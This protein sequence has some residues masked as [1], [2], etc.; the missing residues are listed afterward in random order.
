MKVPTQK[1]S[2]KLRNEFL[3]E[4]PSNRTTGHRWEANYDKL[5]L[6]LSTT[7]YKLVSEKTGGGGTESF[8]FIPCEKGITLIRMVYKR[9]WEKINAKEV[10]YEV[11]IDD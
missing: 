8:T 9:P 7:N 4:L 2:V 11:T 1:L 3:I 5:L 6:Q 10:L